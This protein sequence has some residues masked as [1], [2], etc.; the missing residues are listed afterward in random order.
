MENVFTEKDLLFF[1]ENGYVIL[2]QAV[3]PSHVAAAVRA[4][5]D[6][7]EIPSSP[8]DSWY[9]GYV[10]S[11]GA[12]VELYQHQALWDNRQHP[13]VHA[14]FAQLWETPELIVSI[15]RAGFKP[16]LNE[17]YPGRS[18]M[19][20][21]HL[22]ASTDELPIPFRLQGVLALVDTEANQGGFHC[23]PGW[24]KRTEDWVK[25]LNGRKKIEGEEMNQLPL[26]PVET[27]AGDLIIWHVAL[28][29]GNGWNLSQQPRIS[30]Y[31]N[32]FPA[33]WPS[34]RA[35]QLDPSDQ[36]SRWE[37]ERELRIKAWR[38]HSG[39]IRR[40]PPFPGDERNWEIEHGRTAVLSPLGR[41]LL[42]LDS[43]EGEAASATD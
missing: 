6:F 21:L 5:Y 22:D 31:I 38:E 14:A 42:G 15:D 13:R 25:L 10:A 36:Q 9:T 24:H 23:L 30:Q 1:D 37:R 43:W 2:R 18:K 3:S 8:D 41:R 26:K 19:G 33:R 4:I 32:M 20:F 35:A 11:H 27:A 40:E 39:P 12:N 16:P 28:P 34:S 29:H 7:L 17:N